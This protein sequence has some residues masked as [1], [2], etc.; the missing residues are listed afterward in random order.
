MRLNTVILKLGV[1]LANE[2]QSDQT[3]CNKLFS[4]KLSLCNCSRKTD[5]V[6]RMPENVASRRIFFIKMAAPVF[7]GI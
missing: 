3:K 6:I 7:N 1:L 2:H 5:S 4:Y